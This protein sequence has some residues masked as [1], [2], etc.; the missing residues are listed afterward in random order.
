MTTIIRLPDIDTVERLNR[1]PISVNENE[2]Q[3]LRDMFRLVDAFPN[4]YRYSLRGKVFT[5]ESIPLAA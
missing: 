2:T 5:F 4:K 3:R 1:Q